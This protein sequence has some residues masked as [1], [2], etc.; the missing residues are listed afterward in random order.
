MK[1]RDKVS[2]YEG[3]THRLN[4][5]MPAEVIVGDSGVAMESLEI[6]DPKRRKWLDFIYALEKGIV[7]VVGY[8]ICLRDA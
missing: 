3:A 6:W 1:V 2:L 8:N 4:I 7:E 5:Y